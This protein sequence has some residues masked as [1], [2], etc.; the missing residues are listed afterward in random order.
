MKKTGNKHMKIVAATMM[1]IFSLFACFSGAFAWFLANK[2]AN[3]DSDSF[4]ISDLGTKISQISI[5]DFYGTST[6]SG[7]KY[8]GFNAVPSAW[9]ECADP[10]HPTVIGDATIRL[11]SYSLDYPHHPALVLFTVGGGEETIE[12]VT[13]SPYLAKDK[14]GNATLS[15]SN[16]VATYS[17]LAAKAMVATNG[18]I[19]EVTNDETQSGVY[20]EGG[21]QKHVKTRYQ[22][23]STTGEFELVWVSLGEEYNPLSSIIQTHSFLFTFDSP[24]NKNGNTLNDF[25]VNTSSAAI[26]THSYTNV[27]SSGAV[28]NVQNQQGIWLNTNEFLGPNDTNTNM[29]SF[30]KVIDN[31][32]SVQFNETA[33]FFTGSTVGYKYL[34]IVFDYYPDAVEYLFAYYIGNDFIS[35]GL[36][37]K[38]DWVTR[39]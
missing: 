18:E 15:S 36:S 20:T 16:I 6:E 35:D 38:C 12:G 24:F 34:G 37:F 33:E 11:G 22:Y 3:N 29:A 26:G 7:D 5:H 1:T 30:V 8:Y 17:A 2:N 23:N 25:S 13:E 14:P 32:G 19:F 27:N 9:I 4:E 31:G 39:V 28:I 10:E 21:Q